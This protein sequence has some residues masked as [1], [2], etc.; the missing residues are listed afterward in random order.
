MA[1]I[2]E[3]GHHA[4]ISFLLSPLVPSFRKNT[5]KSFESM[6]SLTLRKLSHITGGFAPS[7]SSTVS[8]NNVRFVSRASTPFR[9]FSSYEGDGY[10]SSEEQKTA[11][12]LG[13]SGALGRTL[14][15]HLSKNLDMHVIG[16]D[17]VDLPS[18]QDS[19]LDTFISIPA[20]NRLTGVGGATEAL[21]SSLCDVM[22]GGEEIDVI[23]CASGGWEGDPAVPGAASGE[24]DFIAGA[25]A[26]GE[27][28]DKMMEM[29]LA[30]VLAA[31]YAANRFMA[32]AGKSVFSL[33]WLQPL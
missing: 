23:V 22:D 15:R 10:H 18:G 28:I 12:V 7:F 20:G 8:S 11:L 33:L 1:S 31:G 14:T 5:A 2:D 26:Y 29:N 9:R 3:Y 32:D 17:V 4:I 27:T 16:V 24:D 30:P 6:R 21:V 13:C 19:Y 25:K